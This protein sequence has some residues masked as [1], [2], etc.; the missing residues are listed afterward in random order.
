MFFIAANNGQIEVF[1]GVDNMIAKVKD[2]NALAYVLKMYNIK[3]A[4]FSSSMDFAD[5]YGF[6][7]YD[8]AKEIWNEAVKLI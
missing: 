7:N 8:D 2:A 5:E 3:D 6:E 4:M 1:N